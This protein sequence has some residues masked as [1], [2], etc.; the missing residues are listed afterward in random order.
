MTIEKI[1]ALSCLKKAERKG[2][3]SKWLSE[4]YADNYEAIATAFGVSAVCAFYWCRG[5]RNPSGINLK[6]LE[7]AMSGYKIPKDEA[8]Y[9]SGERMD[10][11]PIVY[12][13]MPNKKASEY[14]VAGKAVKIT[15]AEKWEDIIDI[16]DIHR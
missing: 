15:D 6:H 8:F 13:L 2:I 16:M 11:K 4:K 1:T 12:H 9:T 14:I 10:G 7:Q 3:I 5:M